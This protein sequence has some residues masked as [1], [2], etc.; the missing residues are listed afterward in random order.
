MEVGAYQLNDGSSL[1][2]ERVIVHP[3]YSYTDSE[4]NIGLLKLQGSVSGNPESIVSSVC[5]PTL[6]AVV[7]EKD[8]CFITGWGSIQGEKIYMYINEC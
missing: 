6:H 8:R 5:L 3:D 4:H 1:N 7:D 2:V